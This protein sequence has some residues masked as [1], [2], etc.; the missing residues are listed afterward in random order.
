MLG[1]APMGNNGPVM[2]PGAAPMG[3]NGPVMIPGAAPTSWKRYRGGS[4]CCALVD[5]WNRDPFRVL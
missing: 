5:I 2:I 4:L 1:A 3:V